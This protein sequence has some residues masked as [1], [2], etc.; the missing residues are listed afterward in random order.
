MTRSRRS[1]RFSRRVSRTGGMTLIEVILAIAILSIG[2]L[3]LVSVF[4]Q[5]MTMMSTS[6]WEVIAKEKAAEA[7][8]SVF[9]ARDTRVVTW[10]RIRN[11]AG[12]SGADGGVFLDGPLR[13]CSAGADGL[14]NTADDFNP[15]VQET[16]V[17]PGPDAL[18]GTNDDVHIPLRIFTRE[19]E[20][21]DVPGNLNLR[22]VRVIVSY[23]VGRLTRQYVVT[24]LISSFA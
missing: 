16:I 4:T 9:T 11:V 8:E 7:I 12:G 20:I 6:Q 13:L 14:V 1:V 2:V 18:L 23:P 19:I 17:N 21:R 22:Q 3:G 15:C 10:A 24:T 5:G